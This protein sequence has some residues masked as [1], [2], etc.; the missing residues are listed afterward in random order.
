MRRQGVVAE[1]LAK[2]DLNAVVEEV[3][4]T[5]RKEYMSSPQVIAP[6]IPGYVNKRNDQTEEA[7][8]QMKYDFYE[9]RRLKI[10]QGIKIE[11]QRILNEEQNGQWN[12][13][14]DYNDEATLTAF[15]GKSQKSIGAASKKR[16]NMSSIASQDNR[17]A[18]MSPDTKKNAMIENEMRAIEKIKI[19]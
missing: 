12:A 11:R 19:R 8:I 17:L 5:L 13:P 14:Y 9:Q 15:E 3:R 10:I 1:E 6:K 4:S 7:L 18:S 16:G 2:V